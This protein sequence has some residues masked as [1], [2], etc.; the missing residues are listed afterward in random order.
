MYNSCTVVTTTTRTE[1]TSK[2]VRSKDDF[3]SGNGKYSSTPRTMSRLSVRGINRTCVRRI[4]A[5][6]EFSFCTLE[7]WPGPVPSSH[8]P[9]LL[10]PTVRVKTV[11]GLSVTYER[12]PVLTDGSS[13][14]TGKE[15]DN[16]SLLESITVNLK[17]WGRVDVHGRTSTTE[18]GV[19][20]R[21]RRS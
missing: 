8:T 12:F 4:C 18:W 11:N 9:L 6:T 16:W 1:D 17:N 20:S 13:L 10:S 7:V 15:K 19:V 14:L 3:T 21:C 2:L 5:P